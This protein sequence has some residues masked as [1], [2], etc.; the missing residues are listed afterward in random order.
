MFQPMAKILRLSIM[1]DKAYW[2]LS[3]IARS[4]LTKVLLSGLVEGPECCKG[5][6]DFMRYTEIL[7]SMREDVF[8]QIKP[9]LNVPWLVI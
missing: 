7:K 3:I 4:N 6:L 8:R 9:M 1:P 5:S 2:K